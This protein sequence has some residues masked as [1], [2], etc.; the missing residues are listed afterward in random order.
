L[1]PTLGPHPLAHHQLPGKIFHQVLNDNVF[2][3]HTSIAYD[4]IY[5]YLSE[6]ERTRFEENLLRPMVAWLTRDENHP[7]FNRIHNH[8]TWTV[9]AAGMAA[10]VLGDDH[11]VEQ[12]LL[13]TDL[14]GE[15]G[16]LRQVDLL[17]SPDGYY[18]EGP[19]YIRYAMMP[20][21]FFAEAI[22][23]MNPE[24]GI[25]EYRDGILQKAVRTT[26]QTALPNGILP[27]I[28]NASKTMD[29]RAPEV[30]LGTD[31][32]YDR[33]PNEDLLGV[34][35]IQGTVILNGSGLAV[36]RD[37]ASREKAPDMTWGSVEFRDGPDGKSGGLGILR[38]GEGADQS[39][40]LLKYGVHGGGHGHF[41]KLHFIF[42]D[43]DR[44]V[45]PDYG[46][47][48]WIN[49]EPKWGGRY[50]PEGRSY[51]P[52]TI[53][54]NTVVIDQQ[55]QNNF[56]RGAADT[57]SGKRHFFEI[58]D[59]N[60]QAVSARADDHYDG[61]DMQRTMLLV[62]DEAM[63]HPFVID[64]FRLRSDVTHTYDYPIHYTGQPM[65]TNFEFER[66]DVLR[67]LGDDD[68]YQHLWLEGRGTTDETVQFTW[69]DGNRYYTLHSAKVLHSAQA[70]TTD[71]LFT[72]IGADDPEFNLRSEPAIILRRADDTHLFAS[73]IEP[74]GYFNEAAETSRRARPRI[75]NI[76]V[77]G[78]DDVASVVRIES[79]DT[80]WTVVV[81]NGHSSSLEREVEFDGR[82]FSLSGN[83]SVHRSDGQ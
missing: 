47:G 25:F 70:P 82:T 45:V 14:S 46:F 59:P 5:G 28:N 16:F 29:L 33:F 71:V 56:D 81:N 38:A 77:I 44:E 68:G 64:L 13:G 3:V 60:I 11:V 51:A 9:A 53:A 43:Q 32:I 26:V 73:V 2:L 10:Y 83:F 6:V 1:Y 67:P 7:E 41:D 30:V 39:M 80:S 63:D 8:G 17:F 23:R 65:L 36:A 20:F 55:A 21:I 69:L 4:T 75:E 66:Q 22:E 37:H 48:R 15:G 52:S 58:S 79:G 12:A 78:H 35:T 50:L 62:R 42:F 61:V 72:R 18:M 24:Q 40:L 54:H 74:H 34:A 49:V 57:V 27:P 31:I 76:E 19:Y